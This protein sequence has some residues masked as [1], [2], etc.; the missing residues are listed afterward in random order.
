[1]N[2]REFV[3]NTV[4][5]ST[6]FAMAPAFL[7]SQVSGARAANVIPIGIGGEHIRHGLFSTQAIRGNTIPGWLQLFE[8][9]VF[10]ANGISAG[11]DDLSSFSFKVGE[12]MFVLAQKQD[13]LFLSSGSDNNSY[14]LHSRAVRMYESSHTTIDL[15]EIPAG[16][17]YPRKCNS[18]GAMILL[19]GSL[20]SAEGEIRP[21]DCLLLKEGENCGPFLS[22]APVRVVTITKTDGSPS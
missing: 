16:L 15:E 22:P 5:T 3:W 4:I 19:E 20:I 7:G 11:E 6:G 17:Y 10:F 14:A 8:R 2:R 1:M 21:F 13:R 18:P 12:Q 9:H